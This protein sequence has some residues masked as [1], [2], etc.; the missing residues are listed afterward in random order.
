MYVLICFA[1]LLVPLPGD[2][3]ENCVCFTA[4]ASVCVVFHF[5]R[6]GML[7]LRKLDDKYDIFQNG[8]HIGMFQLY[9]NRYHMSN[10]Y[11]KLEMEKLDAKISAE[12][13][14]KLREIANRPLQVMVSSDNMALAALLNAGGF[15]CRRKCYEIEA[16]TEDY[17]GGNVD[18][19][20]E[21]CCIGE[22]DYE[23]ACKMM[24]DYYVVTHKAINPWTA[25]YES[26]CENMPAEIVCSK[27]DGKIISLAFI[28]ENEIAYV[29]GMDKQ[30][31]A[32]FAR[33]LAVIMLAKY[34]T[35]S[36]ESDDCDWA[37][38]LLK[39]MFINQDE[40]SLDT[41]VYDI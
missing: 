18:M 19:P 6:F 35:I 1:L 40:R 16:G 9:D 11:V 34:G 30:Q 15:T 36:F 33:C 38:M 23:C 4:Q 8:C 10:C 39:N 21:Y 20:L 7:R 25:D 5:G 31:F 17:I 13:F 3:P 22:P 29:C 2:S 37:A 28:E 12:L 32:D 14:C 27:V 41:Y 24:F 26:F